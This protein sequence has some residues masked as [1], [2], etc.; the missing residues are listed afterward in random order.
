[1][2][3]HSKKYCWK[4]HLVEEICILASSVKRCS[5]PGHQLVL[6]NNHLGPLANH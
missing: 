2:L 1:M 3:N 4:L 6:P 5:P